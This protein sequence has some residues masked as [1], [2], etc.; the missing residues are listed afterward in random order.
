MN[1]KNT[2]KTTVYVKPSII[3]NKVLDYLRAIKASPNAIVAPGIVEDLTAA[4]LYEV[5]TIKDNEDVDISF[6]GK[7]R[8]MLVLDLV[9]KVEH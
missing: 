6:N 1:S 9:I 7:F 8:D 5:G 4:H 2:R 3:N